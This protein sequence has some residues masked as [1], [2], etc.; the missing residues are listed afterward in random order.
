M[1]RKAA[2][3]KN[4][5]RLFFLLAL[6]LTFAIIRISLGLF[7]YLNFN[8]GSYNIHHIY[9]GSVLL[10]LVTIYHIVGW[11]NNF[12][13]VL[14]G[15]SSALIL[16]QLVFLIATDAGDLTYLGPVSFWGAVVS[17]VIVMLIL[18]I[19]HCYKKK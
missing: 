7:P 17:I 1:K 8:L 19:V 5:L 14:A 15:M 12:L 2:S 18:E 6:V 9:L 4:Q 3:H 11:K 10:I 13:A 16:D